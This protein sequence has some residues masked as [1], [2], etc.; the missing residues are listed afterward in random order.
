MS[1]TNFDLNPDV[2]NSLHR[3]SDWRPW[4]K[5]DDSLLSCEDLFNYLLE[6]ILILMV[7]FVCFFPSKMSLPF[8]MVVL[9]YKHLHL[10]K[11]S[12]G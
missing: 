4:D 9:T 3:C 6:V 1:F 11:A 10:K 2:K 8:S 7:F 5:L 12:L